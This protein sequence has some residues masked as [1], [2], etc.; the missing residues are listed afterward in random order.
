MKRRCA[1]GTDN[2]RF[3]QGFAA[4]PPLRA[5]R[6][7]AEQYRTAPQSRAHFFR[8]AKG[9]PQW[10]HSF[11]G[12]SD[13]RRMGPIELAC[14]ECLLEG[15]DNGDADGRRDPSLSIMGAVD[16][17]G[18][19]EIGIASPHFRPPF[20]AARSSGNVIWR[21][22]PDRAALCEMAETNEEGFCDDGAYPY[23]CCF[24]R[25]CAGGGPISGRR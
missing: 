4:S 15:D 14:V 1:S 20:A 21:R 8:Q 2:Q 10:A 13:L 25:P 16:E 9:R 19:H 11:V 18:D 12:R 17:N 24:G 7:R 22:A 6:Q 5:R 23:S 3:H